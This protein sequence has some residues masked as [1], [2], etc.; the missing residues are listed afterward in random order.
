M[1]LVPAFA[2]YPNEAAIIGRL[3]VAYG[4][5]EFIFA[6]C[7]A[8]AMNDIDTAMKV[9]FRMRN[10]GQRLDLIDALLRHKCDE[11]GLASQYA[12]AFGAVCYCKR[13]RN[14]FAH[15]HWAHDATGLFFANLEEAAK[16]TGKPI[17]QN[18]RIT[19]A[20]LQEHESY[21]EYASACLKFIDREFEVR[22]G[23]AKDNP[24]PMPAKRRQPNLHSPDATPPSP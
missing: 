23:R 21:F 19:L 11:I 17:I 16:S 9:I 20:L 12:D 22:G 1:A 7:L 13:I 14:Q 4:E 10:E 15:C 2:H 3:L 18:R 8:D 24:Y 6:L 5:I